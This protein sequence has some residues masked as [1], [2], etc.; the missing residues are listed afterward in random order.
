MDE[1][2]KKTD[3]LDIVKR[4][5]G[6]YAA[7]WSEI[8]NLESV[9]AT[10]ESTGQWVDIREESPEKPGRYLVALRRKAPE[11][12]GGNQCKV[13]ILRFRP[14][15]NFQ[16]PVHFP[17]WINDEIEETITH[18]MPLPDLPEKEIQP[19]WFMENGA[20]F[21]QTMRE[22]KTGTEWWVRTPHPIFDRVPG[23]KEVCTLRDICDGFSSGKFYECCH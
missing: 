10:L 13:T 7:A 20:T 11:S 6:D 1:L 12:L 16:Y 19:I 8:A 21:P 2:I 15:G 5:S 4:T 17:D 22:E 23:L 9:D 3:A 14:D 18:W